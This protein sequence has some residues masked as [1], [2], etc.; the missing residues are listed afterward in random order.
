MQLR[1]VI[2]A[3][4]SATLALVLV[5]GCANY[6]DQGETPAD[7]QRSIDV[8]VGPTLTALYAKVPGSKELADKARGILVFPSVF[9]GGAVVG[10]EYGRGAL[11]VDGRTVGYYKTSSV[12]LGLQIGAQSRSLVLMFM[13]QDA[14]DKLTANNGWTAGADAS[15]ALLHVGANGRLEGTD[16]AAAVNAF[17]LNNEGLMVGASI[18]GTKLTKIQW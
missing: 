2:C 16:G 15:V 13:T 3:A 4:A 14:L 17:A 6:R 9:D 12:S 8:G 18:D 5:G 10:G 7:V 1:T 11:I